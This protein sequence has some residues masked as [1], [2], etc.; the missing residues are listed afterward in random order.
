MSDQPLVPFHAAASALACRIVNNTYLS[1]DGFASMRESCTDPGFAA[2]LARMIEKE[3][4]EPIV[5]P[6]WYVAFPDDGPWFA[7]RYGK[8]GVRVDFLLEGD[9]RTGLAMEVANVIRHDLGERE[10]VDRLVAAEIVGRS[11]NPDQWHV[12][13]IILPIKS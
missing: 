10:E 5:P 6:G 9:K 2:H 13:R 12:E 8:S 4:G 3:L 11:A 7:A 1:L